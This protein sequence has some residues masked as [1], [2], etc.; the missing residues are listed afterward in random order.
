MGV[1]ASIVNDG[2]G[3]PYRLTITSNSSGVSNSMKITTSGDAS[4]SSLLD[5][6]PAGVQ[7]LNQTVAAQNANLTVN[8]INVTS[9]S[10]QVTDAIQ[11]VT[12]SLKKVT[13]STATLNIARDTNTINTAFSGFVSAYNALAAQLTSR[14]AYGSSTST[15]GTLAGDG[16]VR[17]MQDQLRNLFNTAVSG[18]AYSSLAQVGIAFQADGSLKLDSTKLNSVITNNF[19]DL[20]N[21][22][23][24]TTG[25]GTRLDSWATSMLSPGDGLIATRTASLNSS[26]K[27]SNTQIDQL[28]ARLATIKQQYITQYSNLNVLLG[29]M[30]ATSSFLTSQLK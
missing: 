15:A 19:S 20:N 22:L 18:G 6:D 7:N 9:A 13:T 12:L 30:N 5:Y 25:I 26:I 1:T 24:S 21:L 3:T 16:V 8:G 4:I 11:G 23:T 28:T 27:N 17:A 14:S 29:S 2:S 10:N